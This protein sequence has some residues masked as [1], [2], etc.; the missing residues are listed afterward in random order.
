MSNKS[1]TYGILLDLDDNPTQKCVPLES[2]TIISRLAQIYHRRSMSHASLGDVAKLI[3]ELG[4]DI[5][6]DPR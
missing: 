6:I 3:N 2:K 4:F 5:P 1:V